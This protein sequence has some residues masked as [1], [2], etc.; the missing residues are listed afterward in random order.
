MLYES[1][2]NDNDVDGLFSYHN[3]GYEIEN[4]KGLSK[5]I[6]KYDAVI[7]ETKR[8]LNS[9]IT[10]EGVIASIESAKS[11]IVDPKNIDIENSIKSSVSAIEGYLKGWL[12]DKHKIKVKTLGDAIKKIQNKKLIDDNIAKSLEQLY[13]YRNRT[14]NVGHGAP[15]LAE[16]T[17]EDA[18]LFNEMAISF[19]NYL[20]RKCK[21]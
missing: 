9:N 15:D 21:D 3:M 11:S 16:V 10:Y 1:A 19:I 12:L 13:I 4:Q 6:I 14:Q 5:V 7:E 20:H 2:V 8:A 18:L 17:A